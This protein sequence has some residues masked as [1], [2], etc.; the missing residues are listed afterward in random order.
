MMARGCRGCALLKSLVLAGYILLSPI[1]GWVLGLAITTGLLAPEAS[2][3]CS[4]AC[5]HS[6]V[7]QVYL[8]TPAIGLGAVKHKA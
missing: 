4:T 6:F 3:L 7:L 1:A 8:R 5:Y 2:N